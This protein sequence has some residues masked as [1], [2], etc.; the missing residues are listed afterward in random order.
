MAKNPRDRQRRRVELNPQEVKRTLRDAK[1]AI[2]LILQDLQTM[3]RAINAHSTALNSQKMLLNDLWT[4]VQQISDRMGQ[5][6]GAELYPIVSMPP[7]PVEFHF[8]PTTPF[9]HAEKGEPTEP[10]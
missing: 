8:D 1:K 10:V 7:D 9:P 2:D 4:N 6:E 3:A 5:L